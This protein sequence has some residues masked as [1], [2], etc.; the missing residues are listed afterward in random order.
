MT[1]TRRGLNDHLFPSLVAARRIIEAWWIDYN[2]VHPHSSLGGMA[3]AEF[4]NRPA[5]RI[6]TPKLTYPRPENGEHVK[7]R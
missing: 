2:T 1:L 4:I 5:R 7:R 3:P 6:E